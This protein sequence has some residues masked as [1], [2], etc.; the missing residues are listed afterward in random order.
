MHWILSMAWR[1]S[2]GSR[3]R[4]ALYL[5]SMVLGVAALV[6]IQGFGDNLTQTLDAEAKTLLGA[7]YSLEADAPFSDSTEAVID[8]LGGTQA[9]RLSFSSMAS[10]PNA[11][12]TRLATVRAV[13]PGYPFYGEVGTRPDSAASTYFSGRNALVD[14][15]LLT[16]FGVDVGDSIRIGTYTY[17]IA[18]ELVK[19]PRESGIASSLSPRLYIPYREVD[20]TLFG[21]GSR[22]EYEVYFQFADGRDVEALDDRLE[23]FLDRQEVGSDTV[24][25][26]AGNWQEGLGNLYRF[27]SLVG[28]VALLLGSLGVASAVHV[29]IR[30]RIASIAVLRCM[31]AKGRRTFGIYLTQAA[32]LGFIGAL[33]GSLIGVG[34]QAFV[35][36]LLADFLPVQIEFA[37]SWR[38][39]AMGMGIGVGVTLLFALWPLLEV[40]DVSPLRALRS[41]VEPEGGGWRDP[42]RLAIAGS[43]VAGVIG[44][45]MLQAPTWKIGLGYAGGIAVVFGALIAVAW[46]LMAGVRR[47]FPSSWSYPWR[48]GLANLYRPNNQTLVLVLALG[49]GTFLIVTLLL[50]QQTILEQIRVTGGE[51][52]PNL[53]LFD[54]QSDQ[55]DGVA[56]TVKANGLPV[57]ER[58]PIVTMRL[59]GVNGRS[60]ESMRRDSTVDLTWAHRREYRATYRDH[61]TESETLV[62]GTFVGQ[63]QGTPMQN[64]RAVPISIETEIARDEL[65]VGIGDTLTFD[66]QGVPV[67]TY[68]S[69][70]REVDWQRI[71]TNF[72]VVF[73]KG[74][75]EQAPQT[76][77]VLSNAPTKE[78]SAVVQQAVVQKYPNVSAIDLT[79]VLSTF[80]ELFGKMSYVVRFMALFSILTGLI[81]LIGAVVV[82]RM[83]RVQESVLLKTLGAARNTVLK[84][85]SIEYLFLGVFAAGTGSILSIAAAWALSVFVFEGPLLIAPWPLLGGLVAVTVLTIAIGLINSRGI[86]NR[87]P[88]DVLRAEV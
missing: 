34:I 65:N 87:P 74:V 21:P 38:A 71:G 6:A 19:M 69:S 29:Y 75:L 51:G 39:I 79:L 63:V 43:I 42:L 18:G 57:Q 23:P 26:A 70:M 13:E 53:V 11:T 83:Q 27:L 82:S 20:T 36:G 80:E 60:I 14:G 17:R 40:R 8:T 15:A 45:A 24:Q 62:D 12:G 1:D 31:G 67:T 35:P 33:A 73:P 5:S 47:F 84:I 76:F 86:Y 16:Q 68:V 7:D 9:R 55:I 25:E 59:D 56:E 37:L 88:L 78:K 58:V 48:Q 30:R 44:F 3:K 77:V 49:L 32:V 41:N 10:F 81:V 28:F 66:V 85:M 64:G 2:R 50:V 52:R 4:L 54:V 22:A 72:F 61:L 46:L